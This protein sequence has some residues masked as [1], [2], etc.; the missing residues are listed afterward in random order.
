ML[1]LNSNEEAIIGSFIEK[2]VDYIGKTVMLSWDKE[3]IAVAVYDSFIEDENGLDLDD[4]D[5]E[6][7]WSFVFKIITIVGNPPIDITEDG[8]FSVN[9]HTFPQ[10]I[11]IKEAT[12]SDT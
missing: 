9:Y 8:F 2:E 3:N 4:N 12:T 7:Y 6:E 10:S 5:Y 1:Y 11:V